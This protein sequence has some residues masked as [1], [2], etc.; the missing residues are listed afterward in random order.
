METQC[1]KSIL[2]SKASTTA[3]KADGLCN[4]FLLLIG[5]PICL[6]VFVRAAKRRT[7][8]T[9][10]AV[11]SALTFLQGALAIAWGNARTQEMIAM[12]E[13]EG[14]TVHQR[15]IDDAMQ[16]LWFSAG[17]HAV[18]CG[19]FLCAVMIAVVLKRDREPAPE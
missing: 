18:V 12:L 19:A 4:L 6:I 3:W 7:V 14:Q 13:A 1:A 5:L 11:F 10:A 8:I 16:L 15:H 2:P 9:V 17:Q